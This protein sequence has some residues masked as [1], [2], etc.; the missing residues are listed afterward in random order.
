MSNR[1]PDRHLAAAER[2]LTGAD[3]VGEHAV[4][5]GWWPKACACLIRLALEAG[6]HAFW[7]RVAPPVAAT[8]GRT[9][10]LM[11]RRRTGRTVA[12]RMAY[13]WAALS[14]A[15]HHQCYEVAPTAGELRALH[16]EVTALLRLLDEAAARNAPSTDETSLHGQPPGPA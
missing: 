8:S 3:T 13:A 9:K 14:R 16:G 6:L 7:N 5:G 2:M 15:T 1:E 4:S 11:L 10:L 12:G